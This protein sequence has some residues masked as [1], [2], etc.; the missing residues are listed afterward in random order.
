M[1]STPTTPRRLNMTRDAVALRQDTARA[2]ADLGMSY[3]EIGRQCGYVNPDGTVPETSVRG[4]IRRSRNRLARLAEFADNP[5]ALS[6]ERRFGVEIECNR[7]TRQQ[8]YDALVAA[9]IAAELETYNHSTR[10][11][12][13]VI[14]DGSVSGTG[15]EIV[16]P[17]LTGEAG[18]TEMKLV[19]A[20]LKAAGAGVDRSCGMHVHH[21]A[22]DLSP[23]VLARFV[24]SYID[25]QRFI[26]RFVSRSRRSTGSAR[27]CRP[28]SEHEKTNILRTISD[29]RS[30]LGRYDRYRSINV[31]SYPRYGTIE[32]R[33]HQGS[34][35]GRKAEAWVRLG[36]SLVFAAQAMTA[37]EAPL[38]VADS[39]ESL[40]S[41]L[42]S[43]GG[44][45]AAS[46]RYLSR[47]AASLN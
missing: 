37:S 21:D 25:N 47:R 32:V 8:A 19:M 11:Y 18:I 40:L 14:T 9:G 20:T 28:I 36:Q 5:A 46:V 16:S 44:L 7:I 41:T 43:E 12:W 13:K 33:Q 4:A 29:D 30:G 42:Q 26:D 24:S 1:P 23:E 45:N 35:D 10:G 34:L 31:A 15:L 39:V 38:L 17:I 2:L 27:W 6:S 3:D 22:G